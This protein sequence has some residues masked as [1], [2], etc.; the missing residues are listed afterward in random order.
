MLTRDEVLDEL[1]LLTTVEHALVVEHLTVGCALGH[2]LLPEEGGATSDAGRDG[3]STAS[4]LAQDEM[5][6]L[7]R[8]NEVLVAAGRSSRMDRAVEILDASG[9]S[10][11]LE[12]PTADQLAD[13]LGREKR[14]GVAVDEHYRRLLPAVTT[15]PVFEG[16]LLEH[17]RSVVEGGP[18]HTDGYLRLR[19]ALG[20]PVPPDVLRVTRREPAES[21]EE[22]LLGVSD[23]LYRTV[24][25]ALGHRFAQT[26]FFVAA[27][28]GSLAVDTMM[29]PL[30]DSLRLLVQRGL[31]PS[32]NP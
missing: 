5:R 15:A 16:D 9:A 23:R 19:D 29:G 18:T 10:V 1:E 31:L 12:P 27:A 6:H 2:D 32:F 28:F 7:R 21:F 13:L 14:I 20:E 11:P 17:V 24:L 8:L 25:E 26:D 3:A 30:D 22:R 4:S